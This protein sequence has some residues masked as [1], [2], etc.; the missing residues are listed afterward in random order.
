MRA[1]DGR[2]QL[3]SKHELVRALLQVGLG[4]DTLD[5]R[6]LND[7]TRLSVPDSA[8]DS[9]SFT[10]LLRSDARD[11]VN[12][13]KIEPPRLY[14]DPI[15]VVYRK[16]VRTGT[17]PVFEG[18]EFSLHVFL[19]HKKKQGRQRPI[20]D[21]RETNRH[22]KR[23]P[24]VAL[25]SPQALAGLECSADS[26]FWISSPDVRDAFHRMALPEEAREHSAGVRR[27]RT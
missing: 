17:R 12:R 1:V 7:T 23:P 9:V 2:G 24:S 19:V 5:F 4:Y 18:V 6:C 14:Q 15:L 16:F 20:V 22:F 21:A 11:C 26:R 8:V 3:F 10:Q 27:L 13:W 25:A